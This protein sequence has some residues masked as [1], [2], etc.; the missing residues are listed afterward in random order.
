MAERPGIAGLTDDHLRR[1]AAGQVTQSEL[2]RELGVSKQA[3]SKAV[4]RRKGVGATTPAPTPAM[5]SPAPENRPAE[6]HA[7]QK[8]AA[9][10]ANPATNPDA[11]AEAEAEK[12]ASV[13]GSAWRGLASA[14]SV[15][16]VEANRQ[17]MQGQGKLGATA[18]NGLVRTLR[19]SEEGMRR[20]GLL[21]PV[22]GHQ[23]GDQPTQLAVTVLSPAEEA[24]IRATIEEQA[25]DDGLDDSGAAAPLPAP[26]TPEQ[27]APT[28]SLMPTALPAREDFTAWVEGQVHLR[29]AVWLRRLVGALGGQV[30][31]GKDRLVA[32]LLRITGGDPEKLRPLCE[33]AA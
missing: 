25:G 20:L 11:E 6:A 15:L 7:R 23:D 14:Y 8:M 28:A 24:E 29:G 32:E 9:P 30:V 3:I 26:A 4:R 10:V 27:P 21:P 16:I 12:W 17:L 22:G 31:H 1:L 33:L 2:A 19:E 5:E 13:G 18:M